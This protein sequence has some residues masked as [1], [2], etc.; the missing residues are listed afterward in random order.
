MAQGKKLDNG[1]V[2]NQWELQLEPWCPAQIYY[3]FKDNDGG[4]WLIYL[5]WSGER[6][7]EPWS[8]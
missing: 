6:G 2:L 8:A 7:D 5:R 4:N 3:Y 1:I